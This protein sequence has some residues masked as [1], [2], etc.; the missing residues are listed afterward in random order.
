MPHKKHNV[1]AAAVVLSITAVAALIIAALPPSLDIYDAETGKLYAAW[2]AEEGLS[3]SVMYVHSVNQSAVTDYFVIRDGEIWAY[4]SVYSSFGA[5][6]PTEPGVG[7]SLTLNDDGT[8]T[9]SGIH[10]QFPQL[11]FIVGTVSDHVLEI[12]GETVSL[13][14]LCG[15]NAHVVFKI[16]NPI[17]KY[18]F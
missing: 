15:R 10:T 16:R 3:F 6:M 7:E 2:R 11:N 18:I 13:R 5:G 17:F 8:V 12:N 1:I 4:E 14:D 9:L